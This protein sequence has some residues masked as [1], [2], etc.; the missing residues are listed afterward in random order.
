[1]KRKKTVTMLLRGLGGIVDALAVL[2]VVVLSVLLYFE[3]HLME[4]ENGGDYYA[5]KA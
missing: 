2:V 3:T 5:K 1:M 4:L